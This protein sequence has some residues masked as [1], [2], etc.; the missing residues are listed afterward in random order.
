MSGYERK[1]VMAYIKLINKKYKVEIQKKGF[2]RLCRRFHTLGDARKFARD[3]ESSMEGG[4][5]EDYSGSSGTTLKEILIK[6]RDV[7]TFFKKGAREETGTINFLIKH[8]I[9]LNSLMRLKSHHIYKL[10]KEL[11]VTRKPATVKKFVNIICHSWRVA[12]REWGVNLPPENP[13]DLVTLPK[14]DDARDRI[15]TKEEYLKLLESCSTSNLPM[16]KDVVIFAASV[17]ARQ[18]EI[19]KLKRAHIDFNKKQITFFDTKNTA[20]RTIPAPDTVLKLLNKYRFG[21]YVFPTLARRLRKHFK[22]ACKEV[23]IKD[24]RFHDLRAYFCTNALLSGMSIAEV[25][26]VSGHKDWS[27]LKRY[28]RIKPEDLLEKIN[29][30]VNLN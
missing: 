23:G 1:M 29:N 12:K 30:V 8:K 16:L 7:K 22:K 28:T 17:G 11:A 26:A 6:Y 3:I 15:L 5:F 2:P 14:V 9:A 18:G 13:C 21:E 19:L 4:T 27:Q 20:D 25:S 24:F 10:M